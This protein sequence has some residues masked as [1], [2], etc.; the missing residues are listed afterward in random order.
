VISV[1]FAASIA[2][3]ALVSAWVLFYL[4]GRLRELDGYVVR[5]EHCLSRVCDR[6]GRLEAI[7]NGGAPYRAR[8]IA[9]PNPPVTTEEWNRRQRVR[10]TATP[11]PGTPRPS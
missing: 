11:V 9:I 1:V 7:E 5:L 2:I 3:A 8:D 10:I 6:L 4:L